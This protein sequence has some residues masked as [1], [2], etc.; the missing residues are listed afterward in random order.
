MLHSIGVYLVLVHQYV[1]R[2]GRVEQLL[3]LRTAATSL[4]LESQFEIAT[5]NILNLSR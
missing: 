3:V 2:N 4:W 5:E 1:S